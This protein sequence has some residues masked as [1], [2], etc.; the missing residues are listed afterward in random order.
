MEDGREYHGPLIGGIGPA[1]F[2]EDAF[3]GIELGLGVRTPVF[4][5]GNEVGGWDSAEF[6]DTVT[7]F[8]GGM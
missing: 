4:G 5:M 8:H 1:N 7:G 3:E 6:L 2:V